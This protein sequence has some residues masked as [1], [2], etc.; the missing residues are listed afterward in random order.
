MWIVVLIQVRKHKYDIKKE[1]T[2]PIEFADVESLIGERGAPSMAARRQAPPEDR[3]RQQYL[4]GS[5]PR[6]HHTRD[7]FRI[8]RH[9]LRNYMYTNKK[10]ASPSRT[11]VQ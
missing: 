9:H 6:L 1:T 5:T 4:T 11:V 10:K 3:R 2:S 8:V 7:G